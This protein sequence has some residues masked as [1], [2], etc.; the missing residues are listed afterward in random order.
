MLMETGESPVQCRCCVGG[1]FL[2]RMSLEIICGKAK[3]VIDAQVR[4]QA[5]CVSY[6]LRATVIKD[7][8]TD[9]K[10]TQELSYRITGR[11]PG[12]SREKSVYC[13]AYTG[14]SCF[15]NADKHSLAS[16]ARSTKRRVRGMLMSVGVESSH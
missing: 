9:R 5:L 2:Q 14:F 11:L 12:R 3:K 16:S 8:Q 15:L 4:I 7:R 13:A 1:V 6:L 10:K